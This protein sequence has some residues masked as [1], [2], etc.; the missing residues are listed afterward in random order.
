LD[1]ESALFCHD[2]FALIAPNNISPAHNFASIVYKV[3]PGLDD[4]GISLHCADCSRSWSHF[5]FQTYG[6]HAHRN[7]ELRLH[8]L[9]AESFRSAAWRSCPFRSPPVDRIRPE[10]SRKSSEACQFCWK[11]FLDNE[12]IMFCRSCG[13]CCCVDCIESGRASHYH[14][15]PLIF[16]TL[17]PEKPAPRDLWK[18]VL[19]ETLLDD[20][21]C[22]V[23]QQVFASVLNP[24]LACHYCSGFN[25]CSKCFLDPEIDLEHSKNMSCKSQL[26]HWNLHTT[27]GAD[28]EY[29][30][31]QLDKADDVAAQSDVD[32]LIRI[33]PDLP[34]GWDSSIS[35]DGQPF[36]IELST[37][38]QTIKDPRVALISIQ[39]SNLS[40]PLPLGWETMRTQAGVPYFA[41]RKSRKTTWTDPR[42]AVVNDGLPQ[43]WEPRFTDDS[44]LYYVD[45]NTKTTSFQ[46]PKSKKTTIVEPMENST[47]EGGMNTDHADMPRTTEDNN[48][49]QGSFPVR[50]PQSNHSII[51]PISLISS[52]SH[53]RFTTVLNDHKR[54]NA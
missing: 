24:Y 28:P 42:I 3:D 44:I 7:W 17:L 23:C 51:A 41:H 53:R 49:S 21:T 39:E 40:F 48:S 36:F 16:I 14:S 34:S 12:K 20:K 46:H 27:G 33:C 37:M 35:T 45:H 47:T 29:I 18:H 26:P 50:L 25:V 30:A 9:K 43:G 11:T 10:H 38:K 4:D 22:D 8:P 2:C 19:E 5:S 52:N 1:C 13:Y 54:D 32:T 31:E 6:R 15:E